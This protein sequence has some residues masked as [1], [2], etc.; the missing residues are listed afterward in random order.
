MCITPL[1]DSLQSRFDCYGRYG[2]FEPHRRIPFAYVFHAAALSK[3]TA[4]MGEM[5]GSAVVITGIRLRLKRA[6]LRPLDSQQ[7]AVVR[8]WQ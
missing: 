3:A 8:V 4:V 1:N 7:V 6:N 5:A 2:E